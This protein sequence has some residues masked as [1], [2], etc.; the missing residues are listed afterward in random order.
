M[1]FDED[2]NLVT[3]QGDRT[4]EKA[5]QRPRKVNLKPLQR[6][7]ASRDQIFSHSERFRRIKK[8]KGESLSIRLYGVFK[9]VV[10]IDHLKVIKDMRLR[11]SAM[12]LLK[13]KKP[14]QYE[15]GPPYGPDESGHEN[16]RPDRLALDPLPDGA[17]TSNIKKKVLY[18]ELF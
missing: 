8:S 11:E 6:R 16:P 4:P 5:M 10:N 2:S 14:T 12:G 7:S 13:K 1:Q 3:A 18:T 17:D 9:L 15:K